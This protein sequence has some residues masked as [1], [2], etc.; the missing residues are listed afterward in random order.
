MPYQMSVLVPLSADETFALLT[1]PDRLRRWQVITAR[2]DLRAGGGYRWT[3]IPGLS[4]SGTFSEVEPGRRVV[5]SWGWEGMAD[6]P[7]GA[8]TVTITLEP[9]AHGT[10]VTLVHEGLTGEQAASH[11]DGWEH[12]L[13]RLAD[14]GARGDAG[15]DDWVLAARD[16][17]PIMAAEASLAACQLVLRG[18]PA[19]GYGLP[20]AACPEFTVSELTDHLL[21]SITYFG[22]AAGVE[23]PGTAAATLEAQVANAGQAAL[24]AW[25][26]RGL[27]GMVMAA[28]SEMPAAIAVG[29]L[30]IEL[31]VHAW[32]FAQATGQQVTA[33]DALTQHVLDAAHKIITP[34]IRVGRFADA[35]QAGPDAGALG[36]LIAF[37]GRTA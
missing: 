27:D 15:A 20:A 3:I 19:A 13:G 12:Y 17:D 5:F 8:S 28:G 36:A 25:N 1:E 7:A 14:A 32:D 18:I 30:S 9:A 16:L 11:A 29:I 2:V 33:S 37:T 22:G 6:L 35:V 34:E 10:M 26:A 24:E 23:I 31:L 21:G 4:A